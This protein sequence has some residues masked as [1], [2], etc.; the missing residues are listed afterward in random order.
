MPLFHAVALID[1]HTAHVLQF[2]TAHS[3]EETVQEHFRATSQHGSSVRSEHEFFGEVCDALDGVTEVLIAGGHTALAD[4]KHYV[5]KHRASTAKRI[6]GYEVVDH[7]SDKQLVALAR[8]FFAKHDA[9]VG[10]PL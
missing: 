9:M 1:H 4:F 8:K 5:E 10:I 3:Q 2:G 7:P 6:A